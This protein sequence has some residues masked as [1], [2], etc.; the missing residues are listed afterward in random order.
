M[1]V[2][3]RPALLMSWRECCH[4]AYPDAYGVFARMLRTNLALRTLMSVPRIR[5]QG[6][7]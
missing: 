3:Q 7:S 1:G 2:A 6:L 4:L 5:I